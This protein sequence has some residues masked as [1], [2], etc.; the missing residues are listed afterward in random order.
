MCNYTVLPAMM[1]FIKFA[2]R[3]LPISHWHIKLFGTRA[4]IIPKVSKYIAKTLGV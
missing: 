3:S 4:A 1:V 2:S